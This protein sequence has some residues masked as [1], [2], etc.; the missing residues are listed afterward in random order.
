MPGWHE[1]TKELVAAGKIHLL[2]VTQEQH[3]E[4]C[5]LFAQW[6]QLKWPI[7]HDPINLL[8]SKAVPIV[9]AID[10]HGIV[11]STKPTKAWVRDEFVQKQYKADLAQAKPKEIEQSKGDKAMLWKPSEPGVAVHEYTSAMLGKK[12]AVSLFRLGV[13]LRARHDSSD[14]RP[15]DFMR[16]VEA[17]SGALS[18]DPNQYIWRR[19][20]QQYGPRLKKPY[21]FYDWVDKANTEI[22]KRGD[23]PIE[24]R[25][26]LSGA[27]IATPTKTFAVSEAEETSPDPSNR[28]T[29]DAGQFVSTNVAIAPTGVKPGESIRLHL[30]F[31]VAGKSVHWNNE[32]EPLRVWIDPV[33]G[34][35]PEQRLLTYQ[36][37]P[38]AAE[39]TERRKLE[40][41]IKSDSELQNQKIKAFA[42]YY[43][44]EKI[45]GQ[46]LL[47]RQDFSIEVSIR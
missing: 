37:I 20:I 22:K 12:S 13:A 17:W 47:R 23:T 7:L 29:R 6:K 44:C 1:A 43:V 4:R 31:S 36:G 42:L 18:I 14:R 5:R 46:C 8:G 16:A 21:P 35:T 28:I 27:E 25:V 19:R 24:L 26:P 15:H 2:G 32:A 11:R 3:A 34:W 41:E 33:D 38:S 39:S 40:V 10:E 30:E 9:I 45:G